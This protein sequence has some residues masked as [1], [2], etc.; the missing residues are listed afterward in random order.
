MKKREFSLSI[1]VA[2]VAGCDYD[3]TITAQ[4]DVYTRMEDCVADWGDVQLCQ[5]MDATASAERV[6]EQ[7]G[8]DGKS[9]GASA[10][11]Y[12]YFYGPT[13][14]GSNRVAYVGE[15]EVHPTANRATNF[16]S[17][18]VRSSTLPSNVGR[19]VSR[20]GFGSTGRSVSVSGHGSS[21]G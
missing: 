9:G 4:R 6:K 18:S 17:T 1:L 10:V 13:Y 8:G 5:Q 7:Q 12:P 3:P 2:L 11:V 21:G 19:A 14:Y 15:R 16:R 20:G